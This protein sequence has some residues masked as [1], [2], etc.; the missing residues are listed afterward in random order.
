MKC[1]CARYLVCFYLKVGCFSSIQMFSTLQIV[2]LPHA[3]SEVWTYF[4]FVADQ[5]GQILDRTKVVCR[6]CSSS[7]CYSGNTTNFYSHLKSMHSEV[8][9]R[10][11]PV[12]NSRSVKRTYSSMSNNNDNA[13][14]ADYLNDTTNTSS[15]GVHSRLSQHEVALADDEAIPPRSRSDLIHVDDIT[16]SI[17]D[18]L[19]TDCRPVAV[20]QGK[21]FHQMLRLLAPGYTLPDK[22][23][24]AQSVRRKYELMRTEREQ[25]VIDRMSTMDY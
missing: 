20:T 7:F 8:Q 5:E 22:A 6:L 9:I 10:S 21:G 11:V 19:V 4:G 12:K 23:K 25:G 18:F 3:R 13:D 17:V 24:L 2:P 14:D 15:S 16:Q 1:R